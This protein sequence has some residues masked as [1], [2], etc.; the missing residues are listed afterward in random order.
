MKNS[1][2]FYDDLAKS[3]INIT[4]YNYKE[5]K[6][7]NPFLIFINYNIRQI[8]SFDCNPFAITKSNYKKFRLCKNSDYQ[9]ISYNGYVDSIL[10]MTG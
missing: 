1:Y 8:Y 9:R 5:D 10:S 3:F 7:T 2:I 4:A 6:T